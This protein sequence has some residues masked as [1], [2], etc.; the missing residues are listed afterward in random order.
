MILQVPPSRGD[1]V[2][3]LGTFLIG[4]VF[5]AF[6]LQVA[7]TFF[8]KQPP[9]KRAILVGI[10]PT[11]VAMALIQFHPVV[12]ITTGFIADAAAIRFVYGTPPR[13]TVLIAAFHFAAAITLSILAAYLFTLLLAFL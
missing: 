2:S 1:P 8:L 11:V 3:L 5:F 4:W 12:V 6:T 10:I 13:T 9:W 7:A